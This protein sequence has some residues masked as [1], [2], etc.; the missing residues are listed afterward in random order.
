M[1]SHPLPRSTLEQEIL[2]VTELT[3]SIKE[4]LESQFSWVQVKGEVVNLRKQTS[5]HLYFT[6]KDAHSQISVVLF[7]HNASSI[8][9]LPK[10]GDQVVVR[11]ELNL[12]LPRGNYQIIARTLNYVG[13][14]ELLL[15]LHERKAELEKRG[16]FDPTHKKP[17]PIFPK[18]IG[19]VTS[20]TGS[21]IQDILRILKRRF[22]YFHLILN[23][24]RVQGN[25][26][27]EEIAQ[28][29]HSFNQ[30]RLA[31]VLIVG[32]GGGSLED[33][34]AFNEECVAAAI[35]LSDIPVITA[36]GHETDLSIADYV[37][38]VHAPT[39]SAAAE[40]AIREWTAHSHFLRNVQQQA[41]HAITHTLRYLY[42]QLAG[43]ERQPYIQSP[44]L[45]LLPYTQRLDEWVQALGQTVNA[46]FQRKG[47]QLHRCH[48]LLEGLKPTARIAQTRKQFALYFHRCQHGFFY[49]SAHKKEMLC[50]ITESIAYKQK[51]IIWKKTLSLRSFPSPSLLIKQ[52]QKSLF[53]KKER[54]TQLIH[55]L[56]SIDP[57]NLLKRGYC[58]PFSEKEHSITMESRRLQP[59][60]RLV[61]LFDD[62]KV[63]VVVDRLIPK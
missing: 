26:A 47:D 10:D 6:L 37:A 56:R 7:R 24:V 14:G 52:I 40:I 20:P 36:I 27:A 16:W 63:S 39:P 50:A 21:V 19:V 55:H 29:I 5:G 35:F 28:A 9:R 30:H 61:L 41:L 51:E 2:T 46:Y 45:L 62:G 34:W 25:G 23:P 22:P 48:Q 4:W 60:E 54:L 17:L 15:Q 11:G 32:R 1:M 59:G 49:Y 33:L 58:I 13:I 8:S 53:V 38:D 44:H 43:L 31:D 42:S 57:K 12:Y 18:T 3:T